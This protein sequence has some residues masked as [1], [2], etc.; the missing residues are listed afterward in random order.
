[1]WPRSHLDVSPL[2]I[3]N[4]YLIGTANS[5]CNC[6]GAEATSAVRQVVWKRAAII[7]SG[8]IGADVCSKAFDLKQPADVLSGF[9]ED[10]QPKINNRPK[11]QNNLADSKM[12]V[13]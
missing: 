9:V 11:I 4:D 13:S 8:T 5:R 6:R 1:M 7:R 2:S 3:L 12:K 10:L